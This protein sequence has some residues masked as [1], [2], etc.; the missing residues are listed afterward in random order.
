MAKKKKTTIKYVSKGQRPNVS[1]D[2]LKDVRRN[3][4]MTPERMLQ[5]QASKDSIAFRQH[6]TVREIELFKK[7][8]K[9][10]ET[11]VAAKFLMNKFA[12]CGLNW[13]AAIQ[14]ILTGYEGS[15][16]RK[17]NPILRNWNKEQEKAQRSLFGQSI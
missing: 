2:I 12:C 13:G 10:Q 14:A 17:W 1:R 7:Y 5:S 15:L 3:R 11:V 6:K 9:H 4:I 8:R 16:A